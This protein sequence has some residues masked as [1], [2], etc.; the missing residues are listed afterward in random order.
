MRKSFYDTKQDLYD[1]T[2]TLKKNQL[3]LLKMKRTI[4]EIKISLERI[5]NRGP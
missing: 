2:D 4:K 5:N 1:E 3:E